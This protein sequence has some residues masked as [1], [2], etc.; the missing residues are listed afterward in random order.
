MSF[1]AQLMYEYRKKR[2]CMGGGIMHHCMMG[3]TLLQLK[4]KSS[5]DFASN[6]DECRERRKHC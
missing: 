6:D 2:T 4:G 5:L 3:A 1:V